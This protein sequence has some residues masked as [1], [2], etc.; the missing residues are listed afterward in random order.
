VQSL[1]QENVVLSKSKREFECRLQ[2]IKHQAQELD[3]IRRSLHTQLSALSRT[4]EMS[5]NAFSI[6]QTS[7]KQDSKRP[8]YEMSLQSPKAASWATDQATTSS[9]FEDIICEADTAQAAS[10]SMR[11]QLRQL[12]AEHEEGQ[13]VV[14]EKVTHAL[15]QEVDQLKSQKRDM[16]IERGEIRV[17]RNMALRLQTQQEVSLGLT[18]GPHSSSHRS[19]AQRDDRPLSKYSNHGAASEHKATTRASARTEKDL[20][21]TRSSMSNLASANQSLTLGVQSKQAE[22]EQQTQLL[23]LRKKAADNRWVQ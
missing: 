10:Q 13:K 15:K 16:M 3:R 5:N 21:A 18:L 23:H 20:T 17:A 11:Q 22:I 14:Q 4:L 12:L 1:Q 9:K 8:H 6:Y 2:A 19:V 7:P